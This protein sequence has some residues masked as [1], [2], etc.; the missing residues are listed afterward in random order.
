MAQNPDKYLPF[1]TRGD[2]EGKAS[3]HNQ[4]IF[5]TFLTQSQESGFWGG[6]H[7]LVA[8]SCAYQIRLVVL[9]HEGRTYDN[10]PGSEQPTRTIFLWYNGANH[11]EIIWNPS[12]HS[13]SSSSSSNPPATQVPPPKNK[14]PTRTF[15]KSTEST[16]EPTETLL[17]KKIVTFQEATPAN[18]QLR[19]H[20]DPR[21]LAVAPT[22][23]PLK[24]TIEKIR[25][26]KPV[27]PANTSLPKRQ[28]V[29]VIPR[30]NPVG[31][32]FPWNQPLSPELKE[33]KRV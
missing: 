31:C 15:L 23:P 8:L 24:S 9:S 22:S 1:V 32:K 19:E 21:L 18:S 28:P 25:K 33:K 13:V 2:L 10:I 26:T 14:T 20:F 16:K 4:D 11:Y 5:G 30:L 29:V 27:N 6:D 17:P 12:L 3:L 7:H